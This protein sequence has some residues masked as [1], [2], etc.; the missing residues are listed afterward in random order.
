MNILRIFPKEEA[1]THEQAF[2][3][4]FILLSLLYVNELSESDVK[5]L[6]QVFRYS[7]S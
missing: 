3:W 4:K 5:D 2:V 6:I 7:V 1:R